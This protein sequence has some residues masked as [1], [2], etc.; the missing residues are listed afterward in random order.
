MFLDE[1]PSIGLSLFRIAVAVTVGCH[2]IPSLLQ[3]QDNYLAA[4]FKEYNGSFFPIW[5]LQLVAQSPDGLVIALMWLFYLSWGCFLVGLWSQAGCI[6]MNACCYYFYARNSL[7]I[8]TLSFDI[9]LVT[10]ALMCVTSYH[11]DFLSIDSLRRGRPDAYR[12]PRPFFIQRLLQC[13]IWWTFWYTA[14]SKF[15]AGGNW[16]TDKPF[17]YLTHYP[18]MGV[19]REFPLRGVFAQH[20]AVCYGL[21]IA[22]MA[23][24]L[25]LPVL[26]FL[27]RTRPI[28]LLLGLAFHVML[29]VTL[30]VP[31]IF[32]FLFPA[33]MLLFVDPEACVRW[34]EA[35][36]AA[37]T[38]RPR[39]TL[40]YDGDCGFCL[41]SLRRLWVL[42]LFRQIETIDFHAVPNLSALHPAL[43]AERC[44]QRMQLVE[45]SGKLSDGF[46]A[47]RRMAL[48]LP[49]LWPVAPFCYVPG[50]GWIG[51]GVYDWVARHRQTN[52]CTTGTARSDSSK[53]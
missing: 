28:G 35:R 4:G 10:L 48:R 49:L 51:Q 39:P 21:G 34:I 36:Q 47:F 44:R 6:V 14:L 53:T 7:H 29:L 40:L 30:H 25:S 42:D 31:T 41:A 8:G 20:P 11:G 18:P 1:R 5:A 23:C 17:Y 2:V 15:T 27:R 46:F 32:F 37:M 3:L 22:L 9:L 33:Q 19:V 50:A 38:A 16:L 24:E 12:R 45:P 26:L 43:S 52:Q 13:Q